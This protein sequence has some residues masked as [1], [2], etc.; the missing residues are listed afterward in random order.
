[1]KRSLI[2]SSSEFRKRI[3]SAVRSIKKGE[4]RTYGEVAVSVGNPG[5]ARAVGRVMASNKD[6]RVPCH[7]VICAGGRLGGYNTINGPSKEALLRKE[8]AIT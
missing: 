1:M 5:A 8:G 2:K 4:T 7:R 3:E 6:P